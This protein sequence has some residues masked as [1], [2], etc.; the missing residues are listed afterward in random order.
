[1]TELMA[2]SNLDLYIS[3]QSSSSLVT[4]TVTA[5][6]GMTSYNPMMIRSACVSD[7]KQFARC[8]IS[9][10]GSYP[11]Q[12]HVKVVRCKSSELEKSM[13]ESKSELDRSSLSSKLASDEASLMDL[14]CC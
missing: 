14:S 6:S 11:A 8:S 1:M 12:F 7:Q 5:L 9:N 3:I 2:S 13:S 10:S 4:R